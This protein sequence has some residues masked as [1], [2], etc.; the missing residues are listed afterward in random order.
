[1]IKILRQYYS[2]SDTGGAVQ[3][4]EKAGGRFR[5][6]KSDFDLKI[7]S[8]YHKQ[9]QMM[10]KVEAMVHLVFAYVSLKFHQLNAKIVTKVSQI[11]SKNVKKD[12]VAVIDLVDLAFTKVDSVPSGAIV[13]PSSVSVR[14]LQLLS[15]TVYINYRPC[16]LVKPILANPSV[17]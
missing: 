4:A 3:Y 12:Q 8:E 10:T 17:V 7:K 16:F 6:A 2:S 1:M 14:G 5:M 13:S 11:L 15:T 9:Y